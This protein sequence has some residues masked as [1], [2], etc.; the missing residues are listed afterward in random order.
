MYFDCLAMRDFQEVGEWKYISYYDDEKIDFEVELID[1]DSHWSWIR[2]YENGQI[3]LKFN[4]FWWPITYFSTRLSTVSTFLWKDFWEV[5]SAKDGDLVLDYN[6]Y[7]YP[8]D[9][10]E[11]VW[12]YD[13]YVWYYPWI[14]HYVWRYD[15]KFIEYSENEDIKLECEYL[16]WKRNWKFIEYYDNWQIKEEWLFKDNKRE[17][18]YSKYFES[19]QLKE[20]CNYVWW[21]RDWK[22]KEYYE[23]WKIFWE[24]NYSNWELVWK[25]KRYDLE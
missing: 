1:W 17:W 4:S 22:Y 14:I 8:D 16:D 11:Y 23:N 12:H 13:P 15:W 18:K 21:K 25:F 19:G 2:Y 5:I 3:H 9:G 20:E 24:A 10:S 7:K 6:F